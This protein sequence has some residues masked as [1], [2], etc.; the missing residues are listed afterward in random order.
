M[1][2]FWQ[3]ATTAIRGPEP[4]RLAFVVFP[5]LVGRLA[6]GVGRLRCLVLLLAIVA[7][8]RDLGIEASGERCGHGVPGG[9][10]RRVMVIRFFELLQHSGPVGCGGHLVDDGVD[11]LPC[12]RGRTRHLGAT[13]RL[14]EVG[15]RVGHQERSLP[16]T[17]LLPLG[18]Q[19]ARSLVALPGQGLVGPRREGESVRLAARPLDLS[20]ELRMQRPSVPPGRTG[21]LCRLSGGGVRLSQRLKGSDGIDCERPLT[22][23][24][25]T[26][27]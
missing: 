16:A 13:L 21:R 22:F 12:L 20:G 4:G 27:A 19:L 23:E 26:A 25:L 9:A 24:P 15:L 1:L 8:S 7:S 14:P 6:L 3:L 2:K 17:Q 10:Q 5:A 11:Y 18:D